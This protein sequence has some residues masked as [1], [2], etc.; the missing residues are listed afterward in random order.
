MPQYGESLFGS[1][2]TTMS[3]KRCLAETD[4]I[5]LCVNIWE[6]SEFSFLRIFHSYPIEKFL[7]NA[8]LNSG[9]YDTLDEL[10]QYAL[11]HGT[12]YYVIPRFKFIWQSYRIP[13]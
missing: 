1:N 4:T 11:G 13:D 12:S 9:T 5:R 6:D 2:A 8:G 10:K 3:S 7:L